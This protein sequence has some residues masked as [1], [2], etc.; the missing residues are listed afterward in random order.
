MNDT[1]IDKNVTLGV[2][3]SLAKPFTRLVTI[4]AAETFTWTDEYAR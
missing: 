3:G 1:W 2:G 4:P